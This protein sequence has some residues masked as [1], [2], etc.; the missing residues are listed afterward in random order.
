MPKNL[1]DVKAILMKDADGQELYE[2]VSTAILHERNMGKGLVKDVQSKLDL[3][4]GHLKSIGYD[5][6]SSDLETFTKTVKE[7]IEKI[8]AVERKSKESDTELS[9]LRRLT[10]ALQKDLVKE[11]EIRT[12]KETKLKTQTLQSVLMP[13]LQGKIYSA[14]VRVKDLIREGR[15]ELSEDDKVSFK[16]GTEVVD[17]DKGLAAYF[18]ENKAELINT[19]KPGPGGGP[20]KGTTPT[21]TLTRA[22]VDALPPAEV[23]KFFKEGG[24]AVD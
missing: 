12:Q 19:Q 10:D 5:P 4:H 24:K 22:E 3:I 6:T 18:E 20:S 11:K 1:E 2:A 9:E 23:S 16:I 14:D 15:V 17:L 21:K 13:K 7:K 8:P